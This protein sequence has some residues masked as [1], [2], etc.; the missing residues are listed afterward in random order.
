MTFEPSP[1][2]TPDTA[3]SRGEGRSVRGKGGG[4]WW[5]LFAGAMSVAVA[6]AAVDQIVEGSFCGR[7]GQVDTTK[8][9]MRNVQTQVDTY[10]VRKRGAVPSYSEG[11]KAI[12]GDMDQPR[13]GWGNPYLYISPGPN[14][15]PYDLLSFGADG[16]VGG[17]GMDADI[18]LSE[19]KYE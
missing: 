19:I 1:T 9:S 11:L 17:S 12:F 15:L 8:L 13:D 14:G 3:P 16:K 10:M 2:P 7:G 6:W 18:A 5:A 4:S